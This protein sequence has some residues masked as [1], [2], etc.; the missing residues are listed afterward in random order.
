MPVVLAG[1]IAAIVANIVHVGPLLSFFPLKADFTKLNPA[2][3]LKKIFSR[4]SLV[5]LVKLVIKLCFFG[6]VAYAVFK[7]F[8]AYLLNPNHV[9][10]GFI[11]SNWHTAFFTFSFSMLGIFLISAIFDLWYSK[12][13]FARQ[14]KMSMRDVKDEN[15]RQEGDP[16]IKAKRKKKLAELLNTATST[17]NIKNADVIITNPTHVAV[18]LQYRSHSMKFPIVVSKGKGVVAELIK[19]KARKHGIPIMRKPSLARELLKDNKIGE[20][21]APEQQVK[22]AAIY[23]WVLSLPNNKVNLI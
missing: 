19:R 3:G 21:I 12:K 23:R 1:V 7:H 15:K 18:A 10:I 13:D 9:S 11:L 4:R 16:E 17:Q 22:V 20:P 2:K 8:F 14:M 5:E 6:A